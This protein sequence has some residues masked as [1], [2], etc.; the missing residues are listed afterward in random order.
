MVDKLVS[1][2]EMQAVVDSTNV[3]ASKLYNEAVRGGENFVMSPS[4]VS[5]L[6]AMVILRGLYSLIRCFSVG[7]LWIQRDYSKRNPG[8]NEFS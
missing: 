8:G 3:F 4:G 6:M 5:L 1:V 7:E 2:R